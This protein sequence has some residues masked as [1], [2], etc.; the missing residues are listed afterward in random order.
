MFSAAR[1]FVHRCGSLLPGSGLG[2][3]TTG[4]RHPPV[5]HEGVVEK[6]HLPLIMIWC[7]DKRAVNSR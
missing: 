4:L 7:P 1:M 3:P 6:E 5:A 2:T